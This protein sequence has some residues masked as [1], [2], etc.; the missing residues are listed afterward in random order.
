MNMDRFGEDWSRIGI[1]YLTDKSK[2]LT[3]K[4]RKMN[5]M[6]RRLTKLN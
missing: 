2:S 1:Y 3:Y 5:H 6:W 4:F